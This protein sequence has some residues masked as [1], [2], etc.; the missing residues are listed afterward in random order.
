VQTLEPAHALPGAR[1]IPVKD[2]IDAVES[3]NESV[4]QRLEIVF[5]GHGL[6]HHSESVSDV[7]Q[8]TG[9]IVKT[10]GDTFELIL[11]RL[12]SLIK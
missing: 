11:K 2:L 7:V 6:F 1:K 5:G 4:F 10:A 3:F 12:E 8:A 9:D